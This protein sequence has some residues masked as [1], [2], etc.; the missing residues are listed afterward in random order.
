MAD[1]KTSKSKDILE[2]YEAIK[3]DTEKI[4]QQVANLSVDN[5]VLEHENNDLREENQRL[6][7]RISYLEDQIQSHANAA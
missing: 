2:K 7:R 6:R 4:M 3:A 1:K 5:D